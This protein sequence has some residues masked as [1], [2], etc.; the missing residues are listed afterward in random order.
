MVRSPDG[1]FM[2]AFCLKDR[3]NKRFYLAKIKDPVVIPGADF[4]LSLPE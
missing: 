3:S 1:D 4:Q 2:Q